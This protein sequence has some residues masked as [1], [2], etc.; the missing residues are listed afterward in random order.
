MRK[1][2]TQ[3][4]HTFPEAP[5]SLLSCDGLV[6]V[7][8]ALVPP[9]TAG[10]GLSLEADLYHICRLGHSHSQGTCGATRQEAAPDARICGHTGGQG[11]GGLHSY[12]HLTG[13]GSR[14]LLLYKVLKGVQGET[15]NGDS[16]RSWEC[17]HL[18][19][20]AALGNR[21]QFHLTNV[22]PKT[23]RSDFSQQNGSWGQVLSP[24]LPL[25]AVSSWERHPHL[26]GSVSS[27]VGRAWWRL[28][29]MAALGRLRQV[30]LC[31][32]QGYTVRLLSQLPLLQGGHIDMNSAG[33]G[34]RGCGCCLSIVPLAQSP[35]SSL[36]L[37]VIQEA[38]YCHGGCE[39]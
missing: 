10:P 8:S 19:C 29:V 32:F 26:R 33:L 17:V 9:T 4:T 5:D 1:T 16:A 37:P 22:K 36:R 15:Q 13:A 20:S 14:P 3:H 27:Q 21:G 25:P 23:K 35:I 11:S 12:H 39:D 30:G 34:T 2:S 24:A 28:F 38:T 6:G 18:S 7:D 31:E